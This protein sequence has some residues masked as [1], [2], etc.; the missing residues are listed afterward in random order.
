MRSDLKVFTD[1]MAKNEAVFELLKRF[2]ASMTA[3]VA[4]R[5]IY[6]DSFTTKLGRV[7]GIS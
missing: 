2:K 7:C 1:E 6:G 5:T 3:M 4:K